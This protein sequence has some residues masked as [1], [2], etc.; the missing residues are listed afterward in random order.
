M[1]RVLFILPT[2]EIGGTVVSTKNLILLLDKAKYEINVLC[3]TGIGSMK[4]MYN[5][6]QLIPTTFTLSNLTHNSWKDETN[7]FKRLFCGFIR[8]ISKIRR[9]KKLLL[10]TQAKKI[11]AL[12]FDTVIAC[13]EGICTE[14][15]SYIECKNKIAWVR[16]DY[17]RYVKTRN[18]SEEEIVYSKYNNIVCVS[19]LTSDKFKGVFPLY[20]EKTIAICNPQSEEFIIKQ[21]LNNDNDISFTRN[22]FTLISIGRI[23]SIKRFTEIPQIASF[24]ASQNIKFKWYIIGDG[25]EEEKRKIQ[26]NIT[27]EKVEKYVFF[28]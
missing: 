17:S 5:D 26:E 2:F 16:C 28:T 12:N 10:K 25:A 18:K 23:D 4:D 15:V 1:K 22:G 7:I 24:L 9:I 20:A 19:D 11:T 8:K 3:M 13:Q 14:F 6:V 27:K 21:S